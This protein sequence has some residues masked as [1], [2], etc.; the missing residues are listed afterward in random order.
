VYVYFS[1]WINKPSDA[2]RFHCGAITIN[3]HAAP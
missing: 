2:V 3:P 1:S